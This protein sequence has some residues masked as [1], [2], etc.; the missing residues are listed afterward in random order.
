VLG[1]L[2]DSVGFVFVNKLDNIL[3]SW[4]KVTSFAVVSAAYTVVGAAKTVVNAA[5]ATANAA[6]TTACVA[7]SAA[8]V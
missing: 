8:C 4:K 2:I 5:E 1:D 3:T 6:E 7:N